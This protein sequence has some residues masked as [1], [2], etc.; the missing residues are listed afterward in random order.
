VHRRDDH[1][2]A[3]QHDP[4]SRHGAGAGAGC[5]ADDHD[6]DEWVLFS[7]DHDHDHDHRALFSHD[8]HDEQHDDDNDDQHDDYND[9]AA[10][11]RALVHDHHHDHRPC[12]ELVDHDHHTDTHHDDHYCAGIVCSAGIVYSA[13][14]VCWAGIVEGDPTASDP[15]PGRHSGL[16]GMRHG[17]CTP[18]VRP[19]R[20][21]G[22]RVT[23]AGM[24]HAAGPTWRTPPGRDGAHRRAGSGGGARLVTVQDVAVYKADHR[25]LRTSYRTRFPAGNQR[26]STPPT[27]RSHR[28]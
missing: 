15:Q 22:L 9:D 26:E 14:I 19:D 2:A 8:D 27:A 17:P 12:S 6:H 4:R 3:S 7:H 18:R 23:R 21:K 1:R 28:W 5:H 25:R 16:A 11:H 24:A 13:G 10:D 20:L